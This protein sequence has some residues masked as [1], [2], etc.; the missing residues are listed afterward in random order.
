[1]S[2]WRTIFGDAA[3]SHRGVAAGPA[4]PGIRWIGVYPGHVTTGA[5]EGPGFGTGDQ[6]VLDG[7][8]H[9]L[10]RASRPG[11]GDVLLSIDGTDGSVRWAAEGAGRGCTPGVAADGTIWVTRRTPGG[12]ELV[13][14]DPATGQPRPGKV[15]TGGPGEQ[16]Q[17]C[18]SGVKFLADGTVVWME[19]WFVQSDQHV[20]RALD[21]ATMTQR[22]L[23]R[24]DQT[25]YAQFGADDFRI[26]PP[27]APTADALYVFEMRRAPGRSRLE[28]RLDDDRLLVHKLDPASGAT[29]ASVDVPGNLWYRNNAAI[30]VGPAGRIFASSQLDH[31]D[32][33][34][35]EGYV[36][37][38]DDVGDRLQMAWAHAVPRDRGPDDYPVDLDRLGLAD[39]HTL[40]G[41]LS[42]SSGRFGL[43]GIDAATGRLTWLWR[44]RSGVIG[45]FALDADGNA[46]YGGSGNERPLASIAPDGRV[47][48]ILPPPTE[49]IREHGLST[50]TWGVRAVAEDGTVYLMTRAGSQN[51][52]ALVAVGPGRP[53]ERRAGTSRVHTAIEASRTAF[54]Q[55]GNGPA[56]VL[57]RADLYPDALAGAP[58]AYKVGAP[59]LLTPSDGLH[60][61]VRDEIR[62]LGATRAF[63]LGSVAALA[64]QVEADL[65]TLGVTDIRRLGGATRFDTARLIAAEVGGT[66]VVI[67]EGANPDPSR[68]WPDAVAV[69]GLAAA[70]GRPIL[71]VTRD[72]LP[73]ETAQAL[74]AL[75]PSGAF[76]IGGTS[77]VS[78]V[79]ADQVAGH[80]GD[81]TTMPVQRLAGSTRYGTSAAVARQALAEGLSLDVMWLATGTAFPDALAAGAA[82]ALTGGVLL[83]V[84]GRNPAG[85]GDSRAFLAEHRARIGAVYLVGSHGAISEAVEAEIRS[86][87]GR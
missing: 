7:E 66:E 47:R 2:G 68:G 37:A 21:P 43:V 38:V 33:A 44:P 27:G 64:A 24:L 51:V 16:V 49:A 17:E 61:A 82:A 81:G 87:L 39:E 50:L 12:A 31:S 26:A 29:V 73:G 23:R 3:G 58:L 59:L 34:S 60:V 45:G 80:R 76:V 85:G 10:V 74:A 14:L 65:R 52:V 77:A 78:Q 1:V 30:V 35:P 32:P 5:H 48:W 36:F 41:R 57:A 79:V 8:G 22:W 9:L 83:L 11:I 28:V 15:F 13:G 20:L 84:D 70:T 18:T 4:V 62:R 40:I 55:E 46:Y 53:T 6:I 75:R 56:V 19:S 42:G 63:L 54:P 71:L 69:S 72:R 25:R 86:V 67:T